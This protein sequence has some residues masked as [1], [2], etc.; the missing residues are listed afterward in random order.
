M[1]RRSFLSGILA[2]LAAPA[3]VRAGILMPVKPV[4]WTS[5]KF[6]FT[7]PVNTRVSNH[8]DGWLRVETSHPNSVVSAF[9]KL[10]NGVDG[11]PFLHEDGRFDFS[12]LNDGKGVEIREPQQLSVMM[13]QK[14][15]VSGSVLASGHSS[16]YIKTHDWNR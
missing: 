13:L 11:I 9:V 1:D 16:K 10:T 8:A 15:N 6:E 14:E 4:I 5:P 2:S 3:V 12:H 7:L